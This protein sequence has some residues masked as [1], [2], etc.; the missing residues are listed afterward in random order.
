MRTGLIITS[1]KYLLTL[2][3]H[4]LSVFKVFNSTAYIIHWSWGYH[5][6][7][8]DAQS[9][10][11]C[12][13]VWSSRSSMTFWK[14]ILSH[15]HGQRLSQV[16]NQHDAGRKHSLPGLPFNPKDGGNTF[17]WKVRELLLHHTALH[18]R[19]EYSLTY[20]FYQQ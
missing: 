20:I 18:L 9:L 10:L 14:K 11:E 1:S 13:N 8:H 19:R 7:D 15:L 17:L 16:T 4:V 2:N 5:S 3:Q 12:S 6:S